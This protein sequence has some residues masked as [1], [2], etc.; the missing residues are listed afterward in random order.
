MEPGVSHRYVIYLS[1]NPADQQ[2][3]NSIHPMPGLCVWAFQHTLADH[4][5]TSLWT[6]RPWLFLFP[7]DLDI[8]ESQ[9][10]LTYVFCL[11]KNTRLT[12]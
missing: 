1:F 4:P 11:F 2:W 9:F 8:T 12:R 3:M 7:S 6:H 10:F 5:S